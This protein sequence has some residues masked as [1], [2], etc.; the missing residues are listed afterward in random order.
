M[1]RFTGDQVA[2][3]PCDAGRPAPLPSTSLGLCHNDHARRSSYHYGSLSYFLP[4][5]VDHR[6]SFRRTIYLIY[7]HEAL[8]AMFVEGGEGGA[9]KLGASW[10][11]RYWG[12]FR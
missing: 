12:F 8:R 4:L 11:R 2:A 3:C 9:K 10:H 7:M 5:N 1:L 6:T